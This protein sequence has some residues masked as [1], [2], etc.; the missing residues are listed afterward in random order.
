MKIFFHIVRFLV[1]FLFILSGLLKANDPLGLSYKMQEFFD[2]FQIHFMNGLALPFSLAMN[3]AEVVAGVALVLYWNPKL[4]VRF[5]LALIIF[6]TF[7]TGYAVFSGKIKSCGCFGDCVPLSAMQ[8]FIKDIVLLI[9]ILLLI[10]F[11]TKGW[12]KVSKE[13]SIN[14]LILSA[15]LTSLLQWY[16]MQYMPVIDCLPYKIGNHIPILMQPSKNATPDSIVIEFTYL[17]NNKEVK[18]LATD[19]PIDFDSSYTFIS[20]KDKVVKEG[21]GGPVIKDFFLTSVLDTDTTNAILSIENPVWLLVI[22]DNP[23]ESW[24]KNEFAEIVKSME[25][26]SRNYFVITSNWESLLP[27]V[28]SNHILKADATLIKTLS[29]T[30]AV[31][32]ELQSGKII[33]KKP[34]SSFSTSSF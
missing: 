11:Q 28:R 6:F 29:R 18:F 31:W 9:A 2:V 24:W 32:Y 25:S 3:V 26:K 16:V 10:F 1:G 4:I 12:L 20:R 15:I 21:K 5:L 33:S 8:S 7:L 34:I 17:K 30:S 19:F 13:V 22:K 27:Y 23:N 14:W